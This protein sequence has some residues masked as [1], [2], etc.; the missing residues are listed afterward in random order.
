MGYRGS[1]T[2]RGRVSQPAQEF[3][4]A[5]LPGDLLGTRV[6]PYRL[7]QRVGEGGMGVVYLGLDVDQR[8]VAVKVLRPHVAG[9]PDARR[10]LAREVDTLQR[11]QHERIARVLDADVDGA[12][13]YVV[14]EYV[15]A[16]SLD[17]LIRD[18]GPLGAADLVR[19]GFGLGDALGAI[20][21]AGVIH[22]D[23]KPGNVM[24]RDGEPVVI[25]FGIAHIADDSRLTMTGLVMGT[26]GYLSPELIE[27][28]SVDRATDWWGW[29]ATIAF[30]A[31]GRS[32]FGRG[33][34]EAVLDRVRRGEP[35][36]AGVPTVLVPVLAA[37]LA[38]QASDRPRP[39]DLRAA[40]IRAQDEIEFQ[41]SVPTVALSDHAAPTQVVRATVLNAVPAGS[42]VPPPT[43]Q[44]GRPDVGRELSVVEPTQV[45]VV[46]PTR[47]SVVQP[48]RVNPIVSPVVEP[49]P[50]AHDARRGHP[51]VMPPREPARRLSGRRAPAAAPADPRAVTA[52]PQP[53][54]LG[55]HG[56]VLARQS[57]PQPPAAFAPAPA[58]PR[59]G[60][61]PAQLG[62]PVYQPAYA[63][64]PAYVGGAGGHLQPQPGPQLAGYN[65]PPVGVQH[66]QPR[67][68]DG[69]AGGQPESSPARPRP[70]RSGT[71]FAALL[72]V[73]AGFVTAPVV[74]AAAVLVI[75][76]LARTFDRI[77][78]SLLKRRHAR[79]KRRGDIAYGI[80]QS[81]L[82]LI[83]GALWAVPSAL[84]P[85]VLSVCGYFAVAAFVPA[86][87]GV[88]DLAA[89][90]TAGLVF[91]LAH[92]WGLGGPAMRRGSR[93][94]A[95]G[96]T[97]GR[98]GAVIAVIA[99]LV[100]TGLVAT[101]RWNTGST[102]WFPLGADPLSQIVGVTPSDLL[103]QP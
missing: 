29:A 90:G 61:Q 8:A 59:R 102:D 19:L 20:H 2:Y 97:P 21:G 37:A 31:T 52:R 57:A 96:L 92:W 4:S 69:G 73:V 93:M 68:P 48:T 81:P 67:P 12:V 95:R 49:A 65:G 34:M 33:P 39:G 99:L 60:G 36:L 42:D 50:R 82:Q 10:R 44:L 89:T 13:P 78:W 5:R 51:E 79:G 26:P 64:Q 88:A 86:R 58:D 76:A 103:R 87:T 83:A 94:L 27:G 98:A 24:I 55:Q 45:S 32:P 11:V 43:H 101:V 62:H 74:T 6:G 70:A 47:V 54:P 41:A 85:G 16:T 84:L 35:D 63:G 71:M 30:A 75:S 14:T 38:P 40:L 80:V 25:D 23:L 53:A 66:Q 1:V 28:G 56:H 22:R 18:D 15:A 100:C 91:A 17:T 7:V 72:L 46:E 9:D 77:S 3:S